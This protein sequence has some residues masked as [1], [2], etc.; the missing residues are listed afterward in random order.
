[1]NYYR[2]YVGDYL[3]DT[4]RLSMLEHGAY[5]LLLD[6]YY[7]EERPIPLELDDVYRMVRAI[8]P[9][10]RKAVI[11][12]L[13]T[14]F[15]KAEDG[16]RHKRVDH[17][18]STSKQARENGSKGG[19]QR[20]ESDTGL[21]TGRGTGQLSGMGGG[22]G[23]PPTTTHQ[24]PAFSL[25][26]PTTSEASAPSRSALDADDPVIEKIPL[27][28]GTECEV[29]KSFVDELDRLYPAV[30]PVQT[31]REIRGWCLGNPR[32]TKTR[33]GVKAFITGWFARE[34][35]RQSRRAA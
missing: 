19:R 31:L 11:R 33:R 28:D 1:M 23:H 9:E 21:E 24:P 8:M 7:A 25:Q 35:D 5:T 16:Y 17:E 26:S 2:R 18:I 12:V 20:T 13:T 3:R 22:S 34:Q 30:D 10:E 32:R 29:R 4:A 6:Y 14:F 27:C 15:T